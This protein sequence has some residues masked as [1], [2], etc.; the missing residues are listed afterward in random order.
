MTLT[1]KLPPTEGYKRFSQQKMWFTAHFTASD[2][3]SKKSLICLFRF[4]F[5]NL[6]F[7]NKKFTRTYSSKNS[8]L[9]WFD[10]KVFYSSKYVK[11]AIVKSFYWTTNETKSLWNKCVKG[12]NKK[13][14]KRRKTTR[15]YMEMKRSCLG[16]LIRI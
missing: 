16:V 3:H 10:Y 7:L 14:K 2:I 13:N 5:Q 1:W 9:L 11:D 4:R 6:S 8:Y 15:E 12:I